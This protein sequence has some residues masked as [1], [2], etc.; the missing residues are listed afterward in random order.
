LKSLIENLGLTQHS[1]GYAAPELYG[2]SATLTQLYSSVN[3]TNWLLVYH[4]SKCLLFDDPTQTP[5]N[6]STSQGKWGQGWAQSDAPPYDPTNPNSDIDQHNNGMGKFQVQVAPATQ[7]S[8]SQWVTATNTRT[9][10]SPTATSASTSTVSSWPVL[11]DTYDYV[12]VGGGAGGIPMADRLS[13][14][15]KKVLLIDK[16]IASSARWG[17][18]KDGDSEKSGSS[19]NSTPAVRPESHWLYGTNLTWFD[20]PGECNRI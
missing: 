10:T 14:S 15:G 4:C 8:Y 7:A 19:A 9:I 16:G 13:A 12:I 11:I 17:G 3:A 1:R 5:H 18:S 6:I 2:G 20:V